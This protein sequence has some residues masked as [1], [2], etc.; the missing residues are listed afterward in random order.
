MQSVSSRIWTR[1]AVSNSYDDND[2]TTGTSPDTLQVLLV[3]LILVVKMTK[4]TGLW[5][6]ELAWYSPSVT[7]QIGQGREDDEPH[8]TVR[9]RARL[10]L[11]K[12]YSLG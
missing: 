2:Y 3:G 10:L 11:S 4:H 5:G 8:W 9:R 12:C 6:A 7:R 1:V